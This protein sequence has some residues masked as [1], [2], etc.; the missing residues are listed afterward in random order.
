MVSGNGSIRGRGRDRLKQ[1]IKQIGEVSARVA[2]TLTI[3]IPGRSP[4]YISESTI[5]HIRQRHPEDY[6]KYGQHINNILENPD[7]VGMRPTD[8]TLVYIK[9][10]ICGSV[11]VKV[12][13]RATKNKTLFVRS[14]YRIADSRLE[15]YIKKG[16]VKPLT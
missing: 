14:M 9:I 1:T 6:A 11:N 13:I 16:T 8:E 10:F 3:D 2:S 4:I 15:N 12:A 7:Y 5:A